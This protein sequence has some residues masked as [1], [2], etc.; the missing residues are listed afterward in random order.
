MGR[1]LR[2]SP[3]R[4][5]GCWS[6]NACAESGR[7]TADLPASVHATGSSACWCRFHP[8]IPTAPGIPWPATH[9]NLP[10]L[11]P[12]RG[13][14]VRRRAAFF[15]YVKPIRR[16]HKSTV[17][18]RKGRSRRVPN[19]AKVASGCSATSCCSRAFRRAV[20]RVL[21]PHWCVWVCSV[22]RSF[23]CCRTRRT[24]ATQKPKNSAISSVL[25]PC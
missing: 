23:N 9:A 3:P 21:R 20:N 17:E 19:S 16:S 6:D 22:P 18:V 12:R 4:Q 2:A 1:K 5:S 24:A 7:P 8:R 13:D 14:S 25:L 15:L 11:R 10:V